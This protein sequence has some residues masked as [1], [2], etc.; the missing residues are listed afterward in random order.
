MIIA[1]DFDDT[2][3][4]SKW[5]DLGEP[6]RILI[7]GVAESVTKS[8]IPLHPVQRRVYFLLI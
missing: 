4:F 5:P 2:L 6:I 8:L 7:L 1:V 3:C